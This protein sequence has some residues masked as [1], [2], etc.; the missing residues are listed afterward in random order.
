MILWVGAGLAGLIGLV[1]T[2][3]SAGAPK[4]LSAA[5]VSL[6]ILGGAALATARIRFEWQATLLRRAI[7]DGTDPGKT[8]SCTLQ[9][10]PNFGEFAWLI[11]LVC[12]PVAGLVYAAAVWWAIA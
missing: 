3:L 2:N 4:A 11:G 7:E 1:T 8:L 6:I 9:P 12:V 5:T 10:W